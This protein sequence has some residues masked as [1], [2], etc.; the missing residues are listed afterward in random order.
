MGQ[1]HEAFIHIFVHDT[2]TA[3]SP[4]FFSTSPSAKHWEQGRWIRDIL[5]SL[6]SHEI[7]QAKLLL[8]ILTVSYV[9]NVVWIMDMLTL[10]VPSYT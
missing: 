9:R 10:T 1:C 7:V 6:K 3:F 2:G 8:Q 5:K 4:S